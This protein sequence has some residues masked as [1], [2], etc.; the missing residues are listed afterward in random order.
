MNPGLVFVSL[1]L[2]TLMLT[3]GLNRSLVDLTTLERQPAVLVRGLIVVLVLVPAVVFALLW[4]FDL[5][6]QVATGLAVLAAVPGAPMTTKRAEIA[7]AD[8]IYTSS[9]Q[10]ALA[11][12]AIVVTPL[13]LG[14]F[15]A[16]FDL[17]IENVSPIDVAKQI[18]MVTFLPVSIGLM[19]QRFAPKLVAAIIKPINI[20]GLILLVLLV[21]GSVAFV[22]M[23]PD[24]RA[25]L[26]LGGSAMAAIVIMVIAALAI[27]HFAGGDNPARQGGLAVAAVARNIG[28]ALYVLGLS[29]NGQEMMPTV[30]VFLLFGFS[31]AIVYSLWIRRQ[32]A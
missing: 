3:I 18:G 12:L 16:V 11:L 31:L 17:T 23:A 24:L 29:E 21:L 20:L 27:G 10:L 22:V 30:V 4:F 25:G 2:F 1:T 28:L 14:I 13:I 6:P 32:V 15:F 5:S 8:P 7:S 19:L 9:L 26:N